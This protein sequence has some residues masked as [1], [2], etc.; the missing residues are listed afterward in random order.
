[1]NNLY[2]IEINFVFFYF[3]VRLVYK[4]SVEIMKLKGECCILNDFILG[5][6]IFLK[7]FYNYMIVFCSRININGGG[8]K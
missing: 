8:L 4:F 7:K 1:M 6:F 2:V 5:D 3:L